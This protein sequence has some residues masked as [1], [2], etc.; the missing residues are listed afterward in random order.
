MAGNKQ[1]IEQIVKWL[2]S[3]KTGTPQKRAIL[4]YGPPGVGKTVISET[5]AREHGWD[6]VEINA[7]DK[8][9]GDILSKVAGLA[10]TQGS[11]FAKGRLILLD[12]VDGINLREDHGA[13]EALNRM[14]KETHYPVVLTA[15]D[16]WDQKIRSLRET[17]QLIELKRIGLRDGLPFIKKIL[18]KENV[19][20]DEDAMRLLLEKN[21]GDLRSILND[22]QILSSRGE[23]ITSKDVYWLSGRDRTENIFNVLRIVFNA[24]TVAYAKRALGVSDIE[25]D[26]LF[27][28]IIENTPY[29][30]VNP[31][32]LSR[33]MDAL[34]I[35]DLFYARTRRTQDWH[36]VS[37]AYDL[38]TAGVAISKKTPVTGWVPMKFPQRIMAMS[39]S[40]GVRELRKN[41]GLKIGSKCHV[42]SRRAVQQYLPVLGLMFEKSPEEFA[43]SAEWLGAKPELEEYFSVGQ[44]G[45][46]ES[47]KKPTPRK[48]PTKSRGKIRAK[49]SGSLE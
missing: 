29:Q 43:R 17:C 1:A 34:A 25:P 24:K 13:V 36:L 28:W 22:L 21:N 4:L 30:I 49:A 16:P 12:E 6:L 48:P 44:M 14:I 26:M 27:Q 45:T 5:L 35:A 2:A 40:R 3:W 8:R 18:D 37:Y 31:K 41:I 42:S 15:N 33:A 19:R 46:I 10:S 47:K 11:L 38:M 7:S 32:E 20:A 23:N 39:R 9:S